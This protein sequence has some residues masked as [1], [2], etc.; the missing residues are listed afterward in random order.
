MCVDNEIK[1]PDFGVEKK[2]KRVL[3]FWCISMG[4]EKERR[5]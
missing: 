1:H 3:H 4:F 5:L 2:S